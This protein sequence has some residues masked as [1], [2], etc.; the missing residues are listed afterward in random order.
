MNDNNNMGDRIDAGDGDNNAGFDGGDNEWLHQAHENDGDWRFR[1]H[2]QYFDPWANLPFH[3]RGDEEVDEMTRYE[4]MMQMVRVWE[5]RAKERLE[6][7]K[8]VRKVK[9]DMELAV[10]K[11]K[12]ADEED[13]GED[14][15]SVKKSKS[16]G[17]VDDKKVKKANRKLRRRK[18]H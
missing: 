17:C 18:R 7:K 16:E 3:A 6:Q 11:R 8:V 10:R 9:S 4:Y 2:A 13:G 12:R 15:V 1:N 5:E 14:R